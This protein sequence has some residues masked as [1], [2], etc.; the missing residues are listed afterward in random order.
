MWKS[1]PCVWSKDHLQY[2]FIK[3]MYK[4]KKQ[5]E[6]TCMQ[7]VRI[8]TFHTGCNT[9]WQHK[10]RITNLW[11]RFDSTLWR[12]ETRDSS[13]SD[14]HLVLIGLQKNENRSF[15]VEPLK[16][17]DGDFH[18]L[19]RST[20]LQHS[21]HNWLMHLF[22]MQNFRKI[23]LDVKNE[24]SVFCIWYSVWKYLNHICGFALF[25]SCKVSI[26]FPPCIRC[27][28]SRLSRISRV[29]S[30]LLLTSNA[31][32]LLLG[33]PEAHRGREYAYKKHIHGVKALTHTGPPKVNKLF[34]WCC[35]AVWSKHVSIC[36]FISNSA[37]ANILNCM[38]NTLLDLDIL[39]DKTLSKKHGLTYVT[40]VM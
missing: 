38:E 10:D 14:E 12:G 36:S 26:H 35:S 27:G 31:F 34:L 9:N 17:R 5:Q 13:F 19:I 25:F 7:N 33:D 20:S 24:W 1:E 28:C 29:F 30:D 37:L 32:Q 2:Y 18:L 40:S 39:I 22:T 8:E 11:K 6:N 3:V 21:E 16:D 23:N 4:G 15:W